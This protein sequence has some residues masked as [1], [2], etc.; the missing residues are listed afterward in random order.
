M[1]LAPGRWHTQSS[2][3]A[4]NRWGDFIWLWPEGVC[5]LTR[6]QPRKDPRTKADTNTRPLLHLHAHTHSLCPLSLSL[7]L[8]R[9]RT[10]TCTPGMSQGWRGARGIWEGQTFPQVSDCHDSKCATQNNR[11]APLTLNLI[12]MFHPQ[13]EQQIWCWCF[14]TMIFL[15]RWQLHDKKLN[16]VFFNFLKALTML[17]IFI[18][19]GVLNSDRQTADYKSNGVLTLQKLTGGI[20]SQYFFV[21]MLSSPSVEIFL[22]KHWRTT[23]ALWPDKREALVCEW[24]KLY[25]KN[26]SLLKRA[27]E[28]RCLGGWKYSLS[29]FWRW[30]TIIGKYFIFILFLCFY[31]FIMMK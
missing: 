24:V 18:L 8:P 1:A 6:K 19:D 7:C 15:K 12:R 23:S 16:P 13:A 22:S 27:C 21:F 11:L 28:F 29:I 30:K 31:F 14:K 4:T 25:I 2:S 3:K 20:Q 9:A 17:I 5:L 26:I 10:N